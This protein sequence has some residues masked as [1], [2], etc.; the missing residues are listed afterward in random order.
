[1]NKE[2][3]KLDVLY[4]YCSLQTFY[5]IMKK[6][7]VWLSDLSK[8][9]DSQELICLEKI[10][11]ED[12][13]RKVKS[14]IDALNEQKQGLSMSEKIKLDGEILG[15]EFVRLF[16][17]KEFTVPSC[18]GFCLSEKG[19]NLGQWRGY[20]NDGT[21]ISIGFDCDKLKRMIGD[22]KRIAHSKATLT[23]GEVNYVGQRKI[24]EY[25]RGDIEQ[26][27]EQKGASL[28]KMYEKSK[29]KDLPKIENCPEGILSPKAKEAIAEKMIALTEFPFYKMEA[30]KDEAEWRIVFS[31]PVEKI[32][33]EELKEMISKKEFFDEKSQY[34][35]DFKCFSDKFYPENYEYTVRDNMLVSHLEIKLKELKDL[36]HSITIGPK[37]KVT[38]ED[39]KLFLKLND[40]YSD[41]IAIGKSGASYR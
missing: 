11:R 10:V 35:E 38:E 9:N 30:F 22:V 41:S 7:S 4:H 31:L 19:D 24:D 20:G 39:I 14:W 27:V 25:L 21:G 3:R 6:K 36:I 16:S 23:L 28:K 26:F 40:V 29:N 32:S 37:S 34:F 5:N 18:W 1:M 33:P 17:T 15:W 13:T 8:T 2:K 12:L